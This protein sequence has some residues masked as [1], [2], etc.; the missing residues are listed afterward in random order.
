MLA[1]AGGLIA[2]LDHVGRGTLP[3]LLPPVAREARRGIMAMDEA[4]RASLE[5]LRRQGGGR[6]GSL[7]DAIDRCVTGAGARLLAEDLSAPLTDRAAI[8]A[9]LEL[10]ALAAR[11]SAAAR[12]ICARRCARCPTSAARSGGWWR[13]AAARAI[14]GSCA[15]GWTRRGGCATVLARRGDCAR[16][17]RRP[18]CRSLAA[19][20]R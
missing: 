1:A 10:V 14:S 6:A 12:A 17:A 2:Y 8:D 19:T 16:A 7:L 4:T 5:I 13:G 15:T 18:C 9:R 3:L 20:A 11:R